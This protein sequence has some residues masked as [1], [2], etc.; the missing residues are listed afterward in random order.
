MR[1]LIALFGL[2]SISF[3]QKPDTWQ[4]G[5]ECSE[6]AD[7]V[8]ATL[9]EGLSSG[10]FLNWNN[11]YSA[12]Y[13]RCFV[14]LRTLSRFDTLVTLIKIEMMDAFERRPLAAVFPKASPEVCMIDGDDAPCLRA[15][16]FIAEHMTN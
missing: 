5:K 3:A 2:A 14:E 15:R 11:H 1:T 10:E 12:K 16:N 8:V 9:H 13:G 4:K 6:R 7:A